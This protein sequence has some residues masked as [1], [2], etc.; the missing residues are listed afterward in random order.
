MKYIIILGDGMADEPIPALN[1]KTPLE[2]AST[3]NMDYIASLGTLGLIHTIPEGLPPGSDVANL[4]VLGYDPKGCYSGRGPLEAASMGI[5]MEPSDVAFRCNLITLNSDNN[6]KMVD[7]TSGHIDSETAKILIKELNSKLGTDEFAFF[8]GVSYRHIFIWRKGKTEMHTHPPHDITGKTIKEFL[9]IGDGA[10]AIKGI[11]EKAREILTH[12]PINRERKE[13]GQKPAN[14][15][16]LWGQ[17]RVPKIIPLSTIFA[18][19]GGMISAVDLL[20]GIAYYAGLENLPVNGA[21]GYIDTNYA[22]KAKKAIEALNKLDFVF[23]HVEAPDEMGHEGNLEGKIKAIEDIDKFIVGPILNEIVAKQ[24][25]RLMVLSDHPT[26]VRTMTH[27]ANPSP[28]AVISSLDGENMKKR[29]T[30]CEKSAYESGIYISPG[31]TLLGHFLG[32][33][34]AIVSKECK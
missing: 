8:P 21:T 17:G 22:G 26:P 13:R 5:K 2:Y 18:L 14:G 6:P 34:K 16:W 11:M 29:Y 7:F 9:P 3:P 33:W 19:R 32:D 4:S 31:Y 24:E 1:Y 30:F 28:F 25:F 20:K 10:E 15:I 23:L 12:H 27:T